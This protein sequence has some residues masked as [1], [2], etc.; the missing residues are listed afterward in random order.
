MPPARPQQSGERDV[1]KL[2]VEGALVRAESLLIKLK[3]DRKT[4]PPLARQG[5]DA[6][7]SEL[8]EQ[9]RGYRKSL[10]V[11]NGIREQSAWPHGP[12]RQPM[13]AKT[14]D[15]RTAPT[16]LPRRPARR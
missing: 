10:R 13:K 7:I 9:C 15:T 14:N 16:D 6:A 11:M 5:I 3:R 8:A 2:Q 1:G 4:V 12:R